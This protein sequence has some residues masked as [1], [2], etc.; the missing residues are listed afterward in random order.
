M[1]WMDVYLGILF[2]ES[3]SR[4]TIHFKFDARIATR[5][6]N[7]L[8]IVVI[9]QI[10]LTGHVS[11]DT[12]STSTKSNPHVVLRSNQSFIQLSRTNDVSYAN[13]AS[14]VWFFP[15]FR[16]KKIN[17]CSRTWFALILTYFTK[18]NR[19]NEND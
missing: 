11:L 8:N 13:L 10:S 15:C 3:S 4:P 1:H 9:G 19:I 14:Q 2:L 18:S 12:P 16:S 17:S 6:V 5:P 7:L